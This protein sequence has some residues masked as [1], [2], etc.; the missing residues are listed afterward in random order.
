M[1]SELSGNCVHEDVGRT[2]SVW[3][4]LFWAADARRISFFLIL[5]VLAWS[6][7]W[8]LS[9]GIRVAMAEETIGCAANKFRFDKLTLRNMGSVLPPLMLIIQGLFLLT[10]PLDIQRRYLI[11]D[12]WT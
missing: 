10:S 5:L 4:E 8:N 7:S 2:A 12:V 1:F 9:S 6:S 3:L 11:G